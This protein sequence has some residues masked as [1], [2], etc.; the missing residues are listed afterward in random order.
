MRRTLQDYNVPPSQRLDADAV[1][2]QCGTVNPEGTLICKTCGN[3]LRDQRRLRLQAEEQLVIGGELPS[4]R[5]IVLGVI[6]VLGAVAI[7]F[8]GF[9]ADRIMLWLVSSAEYSS[10]GV[11]LWSGEMGRVMSAMEQDLASHM[12]T[13]SQIYSVFQQPIVSESVAGYYVV[14]VRSTGQDYRAVGR[15]VV[16]PQDDNILFVAV[17]DNGAQVRGIAR[18]QESRYIA[19]WENASCQ[20]NGQIGAVSGIVTR[21]EDGRFEGYGGTEL[22]PMNYEFF[23]FKLP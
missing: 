2:A 3:N 17:L 11:N 6:T 9:N 21:R 8:A 20:W 4:S 12:V 14:A 1:C 19:Y 23:A 10:S 18:Q 13:A 22:T 5:N 16:K 15:A 7:I